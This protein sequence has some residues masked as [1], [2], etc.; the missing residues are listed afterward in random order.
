M[1]VPKPLIISKSQPDKTI[2][3]LARNNCFC[4]DEYIL[5]LQKVNRC[6]CSQRAPMNLLI[7]SNTLIGKDFSDWHRALVSYFSKPL[8]A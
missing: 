8:S 6:L 4:F 5:L 2:R 3:L 7:F 1:G